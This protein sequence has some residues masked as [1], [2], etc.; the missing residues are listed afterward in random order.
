MVQ[1][2]LT[3]LYNNKSRNSFRM[4]EEL[5]SVLV[6]ASFEG[7]LE[8]VKELVCQGADIHRID[9]EPLRKASSRGH[10][11][12]VRYLLEHGADP[13]AKG[14]E[15]LQ[16][17]CEGG[18]LEIMKLLVE[19][20]ADPH[21]NNEYVLW[22][23]SWNGYFEIVKFLVEEGK[24]DIH[25][26]KSVAFYWAVYFGHLEIVKYLLKS[27]ANPQSRKIDFIDKEGSIDVSKCLRTFGILPRNIGKKYLY[28]EIL[29][30]LLEYGADVFLTDYL[31]VNPRKRLLL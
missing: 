15:S 23:A 27:G 2:N 14:N 16:E 30:C 12:V 18:Y 29:K 1:L 31:P 13:H 5:Q 17:A 3:R 25:C 6:Q 21:A 4:E 20:G 9:D 22:W 8:K 28:I 11:E 10:L 26:R 7:N 19:Y 24:A